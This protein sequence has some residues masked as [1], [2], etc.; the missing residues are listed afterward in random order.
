MSD[1]LQTLVGLAR[2]TEA[3]V[4]PVV[5]SHYETPL[6]EPTAPRPEIIE[7]TPG[8]IT[9]S[10]RPAESFSAPVADVAAPASKPSDRKSP[11]ADRSPAIPAKEPSGENVLLFPSSPS[12]DRVPPVANAVAHHEPTASR[13]SPTPP[14][15]QHL[16]PSR[17]ETPVPDVPP[18]GFR[19]QLIPRSTSAP[20][21]RPV[22]N[23]PRP[24]D[25]HVTIGRIEV[26][27]APTPERATP[28]SKPSAPALSLD[29]YLKTR[30]G[31]K[32]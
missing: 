18:R 4:R 19:P 10:P 30:D 22:E 25:I 12:A 14:S 15:Q 7:E 9:R 21:V 13:R 3:R 20:A 31:R 26:R 5:R 11:A 1:Y 6:A 24:P 8:K 2:G 32:E 23:S 27:A 17:R 16:R 28:R 29:D